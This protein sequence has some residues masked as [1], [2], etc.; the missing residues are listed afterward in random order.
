MCVCVK[1]PGE[2]G[3]RKDGISVNGTRSRPP[4]N[5]SNRDDTVYKKKLRMGETEKRYRSAMNRLIR[6]AKVRMEE[7]LG[8]GRLSLYSTYEVE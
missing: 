8:Q 4:A 2:G 1:G 7:R 6:R 3:D 5:R